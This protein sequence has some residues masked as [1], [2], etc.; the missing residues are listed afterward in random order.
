M[1][2]RDPVRHIAG[3]C[4]AQVLAISAAILSPLAVGGLIIGLDIGEVEAGALVTMELLV[5]G[6][7]SILVAPLGVKI[8]YR[9]MA[10]AGGILLI[11]GHAGAAQAVS[12]NELYP[13]RILAGVGCGCLAACLPRRWPQ[14]WGWCGD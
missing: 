7:V 5:M 9:I 8:P 4:S 10:L 13:W 11:A 3:A 12:L 6:S 1:Q 14:S 2:N